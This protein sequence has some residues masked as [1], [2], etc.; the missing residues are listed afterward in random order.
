MWL[1]QRLQWRALTLAIVVFYPSNNMLYP[2]E[3]KTN[4]VLMFS[5][6]NCVHEEQADVSCVY[7]HEIVKKSEYVWPW[8]ASCMHQ[9]LC[10][11]SHCAG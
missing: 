9:P 1:S 8:P 5:C 10:G 7:R 4:M 2:K 11:A 3:D 6:K